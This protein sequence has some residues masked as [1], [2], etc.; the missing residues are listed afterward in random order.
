MPGRYTLLCNSSQYVAAPSLYK[1]PGYDPFTDFAPII[2]AGVSPNLIFAHPSFDAKDLQELIAIG[3]TKPL[4]Y[5]S[6]GAGSTPHLTG[7]RLLKLMAQLPVTHIPYS[8]A[9]PAMQ[10]V[11]GGQVPIGITAM[12][13]AVEL[14]KVG[15]LRGIA[16]TSPARMPSLPDVATVAESGFPGYED[17][18]WI[19]FFAPTGTSRAIVNQ[20]NQQI[21]AVLQLPET[22]ERLAAVGFDPVD[23]TPEQ[24]TG[25]I[26]V[27]VA[28]WAQ[29]IKDRARESTDWVSGAPVTGCRRG[30]PGRRTIKPRQQFSSAGYRSP[31]TKPLQHLVRVSAR[32]RRRTA[33]L[34]RN[35]GEVQR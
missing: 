35:A 28:K 18:T 8:S 32:F 26:K 5:G 22:R 1:K 13:P 2:N 14:I 15:K 27:E 16:V 6:A 30:G 17:Y 25:Y 19:G 10:A 31:C 4:S 33:D 21:A 3:R 20:L 23:N 12:P 34:L 11:A 24:F 7:E 9:A 29:V